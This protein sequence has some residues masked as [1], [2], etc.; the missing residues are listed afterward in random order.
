MGEEPLEIPIEDSLDL[1]AIP[2]SE[3]AAVVEAYLEEARRA[4]FPE[5][6]IVH[7]R[8]IGTQRAI[9]RSVLARSS[10]V[11][12]FSDA[13]PDRGGWGATIVVLARDGPAQ[14]TRS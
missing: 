10:H 7:G 13:T 11:R 2:P 12:E 14:A 4:G 3:T 8:G 1:H 6:R 9:V 5:V